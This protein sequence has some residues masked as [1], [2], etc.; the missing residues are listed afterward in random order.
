VLGRGRLIIVYCV[1]CVYPVAGSY[2]N[3]LL[4]NEIKY[5]SLVF[6]KKKLILIYTSISHNSN[7]LI[8]F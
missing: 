6:L 5:S 1:V 7:F 2:L 4:L 8:F 3:S